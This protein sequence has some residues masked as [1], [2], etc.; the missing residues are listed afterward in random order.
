VTITVCWKWVAMG[1]DSD[2]ADARWSGVSP[3]DEAALEIALELGPAHGD[4]TVVCVGPPAADTALREAMAA[5]ARRAVRID[6]GAPME[7]CSVAIALAAHAASSDFV[8]CGDYSLDR[9]TGSVPAFLAH[10]LGSAQALGLVEVET[11]T[12]TS[13]RLRVL[14]RLDGGRRE[15]LDVAAPAVLSVEGSV[16]RLRRS[17]LAAA[18]KAKSAV[19]EVEPSPADTVH[20]AAP[21][22]S[23]PVL[24][25]PYR[26]RARMLPAPAGSVL[27]RVREILDVGGHHGV[28]GEPV[29]LT[30]PEAAARIV[31]QLARWGYLDA[32]GQIARD[33]DAAVDATR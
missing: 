10:E 11:S 1:D 2:I 7:S 28:S 33:Q 27:T 22:L 30:P 4:V 24:V 17:S 23:V 18:L 12:A 20:G 5:G 19:I 26:P 29:E 16:R 15:V 9:G 6:S 31:D 3:A 13:G 14:R 21:S 25:V 32:V 8:I